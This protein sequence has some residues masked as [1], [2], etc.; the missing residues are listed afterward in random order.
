DVPRITELAKSGADRAK[1]E[2]LLARDQ[3]TRPYAAPPGV[4]G[5]RLKLLRTSFIET[6]NSA[7]FKKLLARQ[8]LVHDPMSGE[9]MTRRIERL[10]KTP[11]E[12]VDAAI[13]DATKTDKTEMAKAVV[14]V[15]KAEGK[16]TKVE[17][18]G[19]RVS[20]AGK[21]KKAKLRVSSRNTKVTIAGKKAKRSALKAGMSC[22]FAFQ[23]SAAKS[24]ACK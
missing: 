24:I 2:V 16:I 21:T 3:W 13:S 12:I 22:D 1:L 18:G 5:D 19:R 9:E 20:F 11:P 6:A 14:P 15:V 23:G 8:K 7:A 4:P 10:H 17:R